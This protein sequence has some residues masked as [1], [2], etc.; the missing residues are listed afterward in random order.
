MS[1]GNNDTER[2]SRVP[3]H[4]HTQISTLVPW[5]LKLPSVQ[6]GIA[7]DLLKINLR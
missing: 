4:T 1:N 2:Q 6:S 3:N 5:V 7:S